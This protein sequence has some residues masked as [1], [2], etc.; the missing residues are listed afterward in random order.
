MWIAVQGQFVGWRRRGVSLAEAMLASTILAVV[1]ATA[2]LPFV[3]GTQNVQ[4][5]AKVEQAVALGQALMEEILARPFFDGADRTPSPGPE[6][7]EANR[8]AYRNVDDFHGYSESDRVLRTFS[9]AAV[10]DESL[11][12]FW[13]TASVQ[14][15]SIS[16]SSPAFVRITVNVHFHDTL[17]VTLTRIAARED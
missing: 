9:N 14:Y 2:T 16:G 4:E 15:I 6:A 3:A 13:R 7:D 10:N 8:F 12:G 1:G 17:L 5:S 11:N